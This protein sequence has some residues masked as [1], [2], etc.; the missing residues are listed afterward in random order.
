MTYI[1]VDLEA[2][3]C[4]KGSVKREEM[5]IIEIGAVALSSNSLQVIGSFQSFIKPVRHPVLT[6]FCRALT[7][8]TQQTVDAAAPF[9]AVLSQFIEWIQQHE[10]PV[11]C[12]WGAY[13][14]RQ[15]QQDC[16]FHDTAYPFDD[17]H[18]NIKKRFA[19]NMK[20]KKPV[21]LGKALKIVGLDFQGVAHRGI[22]D[23]Q[24]M[25]RIAS[26]IFR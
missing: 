12:S 2:T 5:E 3:C 6:D 13:D 15:L 17:E 25:A 20:L 4:N 1:I 19:K 11:F 14:K 9:K 24:N 21:G 7:S 18:I 10:A 26:Y 23:A 8:I 16:D 22:D